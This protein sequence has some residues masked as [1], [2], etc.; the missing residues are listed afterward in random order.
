MLRE[1]RSG[2]QS[3]TAPEAQRQLHPVCAVYNRNVAGIVDEALANGDLKV[4]RLFQRTPTRII[5][6]REIRA[7]GFE[8]SIFTNVNT[9]EEYESL[10][11]MVSGPRHE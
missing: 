11:Q 1:A 9:P 10:L 6:E 4:T 3:I 5:E 2:E 8:P 7:A